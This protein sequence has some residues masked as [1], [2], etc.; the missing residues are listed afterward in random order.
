MAGS[1]PYKG[2]AMTNT[3]RITQDIKQMESEGRSREEVTKF[4][5]TS[6]RRWNE[7]T[8]MQLRFKRLLDGK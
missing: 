3:E 7:E 8:L 2:I 1:L 6:L 5:E 4:M